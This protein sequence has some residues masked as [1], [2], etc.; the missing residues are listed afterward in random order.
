MTAKSNTN[1]I[2]KNILDCDNIIK[3]ETKSIMKLNSQLIWN[4]RME[5]KLISKN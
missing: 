1:P 5:K 2:P 3:D 4:L